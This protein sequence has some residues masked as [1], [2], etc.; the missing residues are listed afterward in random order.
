MKTSNN[1]FKQLKFLI[2]DVYDNGE[3]E[4]RN[5]P[6]GR[7]DLLKQD[8][9]RFEIAKLF[10]KLVKET[11]YF[12]KETVVYLM[13]PY[14]NNNQALIMLEKLYG[15]KISQNTL[16]QIWHRDREKFVKEFSE[17]FFMDV[18]LYAT[19]EVDHYR[20]KLEQYLDNIDST[21]LLGACKLNLSSEEFK[22]ET[23]DE[24]FNEFIQK[25]RPYVD[26]NIKKT[27]ESLNVDVLAYIN[28]ITTHKSL[29]EL[30]I[31]RLKK[32][33]KILIKG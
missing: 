2:Y 7:Y 8:N 12:R 16:Y 33:R 30:D 13:D 11:D 1:I 27:Q 31:E 26:V 20:E 9:N 22:Y 3:G 5:T 32:L 21:G 25:I 28:Y 19:A 18:T 14:I 17:H 23:T 6:S 15:I 29:T 24:E 4:F 10:V